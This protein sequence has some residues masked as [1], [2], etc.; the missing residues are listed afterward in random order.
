[1]RLKRL[2]LV[3]VAPLLCQP[4]FAADATMFRGDP[5]HSGIYASAAVA[6]FSRVK[7]KF[8][9]GGMVYS[10]PAVAGVAYV[11]STDGNLYAMD[12]PPEPEMDVRSQE[13]RASSPAVAD[14]LGTLSPTMAIFMPSTPQRG[15]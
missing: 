10:S 8:H 4:L 6:A 7:W 5:Q 9:T 13:P 12:T 15:P 14:G 1:M 11:G 2:L 3:T